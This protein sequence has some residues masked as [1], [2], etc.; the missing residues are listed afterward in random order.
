MHEL[1][2]TLGFAHGGDVD[3]NNKPNY[4]S[5]MNYSFQACGVPASAGLLPGGCDYSRLVSGSLLPPLNETNLD[6]CLGIGGGLGFG[7]MDWDGDTALEG[8]SGCPVV[9]SNVTADVNNDGVC[10]KAG[11]NGTL[12]TTP[13]TDDSQKEA[14][15]NDGPNRV[16]NTAKK[17]G[18]DDE[19]STAVG[20][21]PSQ[22]NPLN[23][24]DDWNHLGASLID[25][26][27]GGS[28]GE[29][30]DEQEPDSRT[31]R[32]SREHMI[33]MTAPNITLDETGP[34]T[35]KPGDLLTYVV[36]IGNTGK[37]PALEAV[38]QETNPAGAVQ[39][40]QLGTLAV[41]AHLSQTTNFTVP[42]NACPGTF[43]GAGATLAFK[44]FVGNEL[45]AVD[46]VP[47]QILD[48]APPTVTLSVSPAVLW[49]PDHKFQTITATLTVTDNCDPNAAVS[50][51]SITSN[52][53][54]AGFIGN[55]DE[56]PDIENAAFGTD[57]R[58][59]SLRSERG[60]GKG[61]TGRVYTITYRVTDTSGNATL[62]TATV[63]VPTNNSG[64]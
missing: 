19:Q 13:V 37:G 48:V 31:L 5:V 44:D 14:G 1:G 16:C 3:V 60:T 29:H 41:G 53:P 50:L 35:G 9:F 11:G 51:V 7:P 63:T 45:T 58:T 52:E 57:D 22:P 28:G 56:G 38:L 15:I 26:S 36:N 40:T 24:F 43:T 25:F 64:K 47:L 39:S 4:L 2:H 62:A 8:L 46:T 21:T 10:I 34:A 12:E 6:E 18:S 59:F 33:Q 54:A 61:S 23:S 30:S 27:T 32:E 49:P 20:G 42:A 17:S 55:G